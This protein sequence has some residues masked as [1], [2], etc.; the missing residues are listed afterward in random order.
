[1]HS[2]FLGKVYEWIQLLFWFPF[3]EPRRRKVSIA[4]GLILIFLIYWRRH[5]RFKEVIH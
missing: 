4:L 1:M 5:Q 2:D 3:V